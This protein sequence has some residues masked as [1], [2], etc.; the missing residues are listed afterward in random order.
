VRT[1]ILDG[2]GNDILIGANKI[3]SVDYGDE[4]SDECHQVMDNVLTEAENL[5]RQMVADGVENVI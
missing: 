1:V 5:F 3:C 4:L 2:G